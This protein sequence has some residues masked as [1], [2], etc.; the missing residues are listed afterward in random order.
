MIL[1]YQLKLARNRESID[2]TNYERSITYAVCL[3]FPHADVTVYED[4][5]EIYDEFD[6]LTNRTSL[7]QM[8]RRISYYCAA[9]RCLV[10]IYGNSKQLFVKME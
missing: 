5:F 7:Q 1:R 10:N 2:L 4:Y 8:G 6:D 3:I 9:L